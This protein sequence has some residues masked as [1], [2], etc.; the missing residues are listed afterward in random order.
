MQFFHWTRI[1]FLCL[2]LGAM[3]V[4]AQAGTLNIFGKAATKS[5]SKKAASTVVKNTASTAEKK[6]AT[7]VGKN[8]ASTAEKKAATTAEKQAVK[9]T[10]PPMT[11]QERQAITKENYLAD[12]KRD[13]GTPAKP[14]PSDRVVNRYVSGEQAAL[15]AEQGLKAGK[16][17]VHTTA[18]VDKGRPSASAAQEKYALEAS[19]EVRETWM[20]PKGTLV[21]PNK[22]IGTTRPGT[23]ELNVSQDIPK[24]QLLRQMPLEQ[25]P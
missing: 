14:L 18:T 25:Y 16:N 19:P 12:L 21:K 8:A 23:G 24:K 6:V 20:L 5:L 4:S 17:G 13:A 1:A 2:C 3:P 9:S 10:T 22:V 7:T 15:E 11:Q